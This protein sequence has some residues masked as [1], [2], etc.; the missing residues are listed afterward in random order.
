MVTSNLAAGPTTLLAIEQVL[1]VPLPRKK[2]L[3]MK[4]EAENPIYE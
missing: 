4:K 1:C 2:G 3:A